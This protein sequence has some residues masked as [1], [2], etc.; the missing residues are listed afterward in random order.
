MKKYNIPYYGAQRAKMRYLQLEDGTQRLICRIL[1]EHNNMVMRMLNED[2]S[3]KRV[4]NHIN[5]LMMKEER[6]NDII[7]VFNGS[8]DTVSDEQ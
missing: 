5:M 7:Q 1:H 6:R 2:G 8:G 3:K 4:F